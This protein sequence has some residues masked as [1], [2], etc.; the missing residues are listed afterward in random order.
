MPPPSQRE[1]RGQSGIMMQPKTTIS[2]FP[3]YQIHVP[4]ESFSNG[5]P[6][7][8]FNRKAHDRW[9]ARHARAL[10]KLH[11]YAPPTHWATIKFNRHETVATIKTFTASLTRAVSYHNRTQP[12]HVAMFGVHH[13]EPDATVHLHVLIRADGTDPQTFLTRATDK[14]NRKH[15][16]AISVPYCVAP[17]D[18]TSVTHYPFKFGSKNKLL[19][20]RSLGMRFVF[21]CGRYF[22]GGKKS[23][24]EREGRAD[25][26]QRKHAAQVDTIICDAEEALQ[27]AEQIVVPAP[28]SR[29]WIA[30]GAYHAAFPG[31]PSGI[32]R[33]KPLPMSRSPPPIAIN[34]VGVRL[35]TG[36]PTTAHADTPG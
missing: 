8:T 20:A 16:T 6:S 4:S 27:S 28:A 15:E 3:T 19:F 1:R 36:V 23:Q 31:P 7:P 10:D 33:P 21:Q 2:T 24:H 5:M 13:I 29:P 17:D 14:F 35:L 11:E 12:G 18:V 30:H 26:I 25:F 32:R 34:G 22:V 9:G